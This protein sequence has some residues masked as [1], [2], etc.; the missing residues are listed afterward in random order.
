M[1]FDQITKGPSNTSGGNLNSPGLTLDSQNNLVAAV[2]DT[3]T[4]RLFQA[5]LAAITAQTAL[6]NVTT[7][8]NLINQTINKGLLNRAGRTVCITGFGIYTSPGTTTPTITIALVLGAVTVCSITSAAISATASTN[9]PFQFLFEFTVVSTGATATVE[10]HGYFTIN[11][12]AN[13]PAAAAADYCDTNAAVS[14]AIDLTGDSSGITTLQVQVS[15]TS[16]ISS[17]QLRLATIEVLS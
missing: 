8:Q 1:S 13:T 6:T 3:R 12:S 11:I 5:I 14:S 4:E 9:M 16:A 7:A 15:A 10:A 17:I 2:G